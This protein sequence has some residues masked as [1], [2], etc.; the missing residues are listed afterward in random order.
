MSQTFVLP[1]VWAGPGM[2]SDLG[3][4]NIGTTPFSGNCEIGHDMNFSCNSGPL[5]HFVCDGSGI[6]NDSSNVVL[7]SNQCGV[8]D[9]ISVSGSAITFTGIEA[10]A[11]PTW[12]SPDV[13]TALDEV[14]NSMVYAVPAFL[15]GIGLFF[16]I[17]FL[18]KIFKRTI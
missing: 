3:N 4:T 17:R 9:E 18:L 15:L 13:T 10:P 8:F 14:S 11:Y 1:F 12:G 6:W 16:V 7:G 5:N 2:S